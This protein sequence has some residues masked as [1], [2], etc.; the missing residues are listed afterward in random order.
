VTELAIPEPADNL[1]SV[2]QQSHMQTQAV[3][4]LGE[5]AHAATAAYQVAERLV[6]T[7]FVPEAF[8][9][10][11]YDATAA[12]LAGTEVGLSPM[13][14]LRSFDVIQGSAAPRAITL[15]AIVQSQGHEVWVKESTATRAIVCGRRRGSNVVET[16]TWTTERAKGLGLTNKHN[17]KAQPQ[18][19][20]VARAT[21][22]LCRLIA[23]DAILGIGYT[24]EEI[25]DGAAP[26]VTAQAEQVEDD[27]PATRKMSRPK[28]NQPTNEPQNIP[29]PDPDTGRAQDPP[30]ESPLL[31]TSSGLAKRMFAS[32][33]DAGI[34]DKDDRLAYVSKVIGRQITTS[35]EMTDA[36]AHLVIDALT[37]ELE[38][39]DKT[40][41]K[42]Q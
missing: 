8:R 10:K 12:I 11:P 22:E 33:G 28:K 35:H 31:D 25:G 20:L 21:S 32:L 26:G 17:W 2:Q 36:D 34:V 24:V 9:N 23:A 27:K 6:Q 15:R 5:W 42:Q 38:Q 14:A 37:Y 16:S 41:G 18:A 40:T 13:S 4:R 29:P 19:M 30:A 7:P 1:P 3:A 39:Q